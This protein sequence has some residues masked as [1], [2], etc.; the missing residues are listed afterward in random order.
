MGL[1]LGTCRLSVWSAWKSSGSI[2][3]RAGDIENHSGRHN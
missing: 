3:E 1:G 2:E